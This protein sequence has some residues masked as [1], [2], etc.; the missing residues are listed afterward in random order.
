MA[1]LGYC[2]ISNL[3][4]ST[5]SKGSIQEIRDIMSHGDLLSSAVSMVPVYQIFFGTP[6]IRNA[7]FEGAISIR[8]YDWELWGDAMMATN[9]I[10]K[11]K[12]SQAAGGMMI[13][14]SGKEQQFWRCV[15]E[16]AL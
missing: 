15:Y 7:A 2:T 6:S 9:K 13:M 11:H 14:T 3:T 16:S 5:K 10:T 4:L 8:E 12:V 1:K